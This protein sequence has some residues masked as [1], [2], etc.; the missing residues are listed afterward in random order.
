MN[1]QFLIFVISILLLTV[2]LSGCNQQKNAV[3]IRIT[4]NITTDLVVT[5]I[6]L[7]G[8]KLDN[9]SV[10]PNSTYIIT[11]L[12]PNR[13]SQGEN[14]SLNFTYR[15]GGRSYISEPD[16]FKYFCYIQINETGEWGRI[17]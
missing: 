12:D 13:Y 16:S 17:N 10:L 6:K 15:V 4:N 7:D 14:H 5:Q 9:F 11:G 8:D 3:D 2:G 1:N